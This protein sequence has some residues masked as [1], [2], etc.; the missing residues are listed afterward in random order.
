MNLRACV[1]MIAIGGGLSGCATVF[2][3]TSQEISVVTNP[4]GAACSIDRQGMAVG[5]IASTPATVNVRKSKY[6]L[7]IRC[8]KPGYQE[9]DYLN[10]SGVTATIAA[11]VAADILLTGGL[12]SIVDS[13]D[14]ADNKY[15]SAVNLT[16]N[17]LAA[18]SAVMSSAAD[19]SVAASTF[20][21]YTQ[22]QAKPKR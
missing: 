11:N 5:T 8:S 4:P 7:M 3:G 18:D 9:A 6:D 20:Q 19:S 2:E 17:P 21:S 13:A 10:H 15:D 1:A 16:L 14:G 22:Y 12:S